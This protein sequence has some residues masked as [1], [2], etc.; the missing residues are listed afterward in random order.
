MN[1]GAVSYFA[2]F[3]ANVILNILLFV[4]WQGSLRGRLLI[5]AAATTALWCGLLGIQENYHIFPA[6]LIWSAELIHSYIW[7]AFLAKL[8]S[9]AEDSPTQ[10]AGIEN[11]RLLRNGLWAAAVIQSLYLWGAPFLEARYPGVFRPAYQL[12]GHIALALTGLTLVEQYFRNTRTDLR[13]RIKFLCFALGGM[14][15]YDF[16]LYSDALLFHR[17]N[18]D[19]WAARGAISALLAP[20][21]AVSAARNPDWALDIF[22]SRQVVFHSVTLLGAG[23]YLLLMAT[24]GYYIRVYGGEWGT[25]AQI[26]F[27]GGAFLLL[28]LLLFSGQMRARMRVFLTKNFFNHA[29]DYRQEWLRIINTLSDT[30]SPLP[31]EQ[32]IVIA[33]GQAVESPSG[34]LWVRESYDRFIQRASFGDPDI[35]I[36]HIDGHD[37][38]IRYMEEKEWILNLEEMVSMPEGYEGLNRPAWLDASPNAWLLVPL[39]HKERE[40]YGVLLL[41][42]PRTPIH[43]NWEVI[44]FLKTS[45]RLAASYLALE[46]AARALAEAR[47]FE[48]FNRLSA[49]VLHDLKNLI[50]QLSLVVRNAERHQHNPEF[51]SDAIRTVD[52]AVGKMSRLM[53]QLKNFG[54]G[55]AL[56]EV[57]LAPLLRDVVA[58]RSG[59]LPAPRLDVMAPR[60]W[61]QADPD[62]L[63]AALEH[64]I[65][66]AQDAAGRGGQVKVRLRPAEDGM[67]QAIVEVEDNGHGM[68]EAFILARLFKPF[69]TTKGLTGMGIGAYESREYVRSLGGDLLVRSEPGGGALFSF[70]IPTVP[71]LVEPAAHEVKSA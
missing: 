16:Y 9:P 22:V 25:V 60:A 1:I 30:R 47:Q 3:A 65:Q 29:Y 46:D 13:W 6:R 37:L 21:L 55:H 34:V 19:I 7:L 49:F 14:F 38:A 33:L 57:E 59:Q 5:F 51:M 44:D 18:P 41:T 17:I 36:P 11:P 52:H 66:N 71:R 45:S 24:A 48:G 27:L 2:G 70:L 69:D 63:A 64:V 54:A 12:I 15:A 50:A 4:S 58:S 10:A 28:A 56:A 20:L 35:N 53:A 62:R 23:I 26:V 61:V 8:L 67:D 42:V 39:A 40:L 31:L 32:R 68:D 43:W